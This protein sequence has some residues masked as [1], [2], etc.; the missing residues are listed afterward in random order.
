MSQDIIAFDIAKAET[1]GRKIRMEADKLKRMA[2][3][4]KRAVDDTPSWWVGSSRNG[5]TRQANE[6]IS[7]M[8]KAV[9]L[10]TELGEDMA[11]IA[12]AK[13]EEEAR[14]KAELQGSLAVGFGTGATGAAPG[15]AASVESSGAMPAAAMVMESGAVTPAMAAATGPTEIWRDMEAGNNA[16]SPN[17]G[18]SQVRATFESRDDVEKVEWERTEEGKSRVTITYNDG[19][20]PQVLLEGLDYYIKDDKSYFYNNVRTILEAQGVKV[21]WQEAPGGGSTIGVRQ[22]GVLVK[23]LEEGTDYFI[24][25]DGKAHFLDMAYGPLPPMKAQ[26]GASSAKGTTSV[27]IYEEY[28]N[29][30]VVDSIKD[31]YKVA[32]GSIDC[33]AAASATVLAIMTGKE[34][35]LNAVK[36]EAWEGRMKWSDVSGLNLGYTLTQAKQYSTEEDALQAV[37]DQLAQGL[38]CIYKLYNPSTGNSHWV[39]VYGYDVQEGSTKALE[40]GNFLMIDPVGGTP[41]RL[42]EHY[43]PE[44]KYETFRNGENVSGAIVFVKEDD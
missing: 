40:L 23:T 20:E 34:V 10:V 17:Q 30:S 19:R 12:K 25:A 15:P 4:L 39:T 26:S 42:D 16:F 8:Y 11:A 27:S 29:I 18:S 14:L 21:E 43:K 41:R 7:Q 38:P 9:H 37:Y 2:D 24:G 33:S 5:F 22:G 28:P 13:K 3:K 6:L 32:Q 36:N 1:S 44:K 31:I 35:T